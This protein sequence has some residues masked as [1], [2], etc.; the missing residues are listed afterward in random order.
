MIEVAIDDYKIRA[1]L[2][3]NDSYCEFWV[4]E[5][6]QHDREILYMG[7]FVKWDGCINFNFDNESV[8]LHCCGRNNAKTFLVEIMDKIYDMAQE[9]MPDNE[10]YLR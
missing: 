9:L 10:G 8:M 2:G 6:D 1:K 3:E 7:G 4:Y 5:I